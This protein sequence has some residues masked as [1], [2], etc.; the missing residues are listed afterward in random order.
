[1]CLIGAGMHPE[2]GTT[3]H[4]HEGE[5]VPGNSEP[6]KAFSL[7]PTLV[8]DT[9][10]MALATVGSTVGSITS[11]F[12]NKGGGATASKGDIE[13]GQPLLDAHNTFGCAIPSFTH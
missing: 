7:P 3:P 8:V 12:K 2:Y 11:M 10:D 5:R 1:M 4:Y 9:L 6:R 13:G